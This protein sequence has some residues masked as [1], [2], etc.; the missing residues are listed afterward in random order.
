[1]LALPGPCE[2]VRSGKEEE[3]EEE[4][5][6]VV[7]VVEQVGV[8]RSA[9]RGHVS[10]IWDLQ[11]PRVEPRCLDY[12]SSANQVLLLEGLKNGI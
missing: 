5:V 11:G 1:M 4:E 6:V 9:T 12:S 8:R 2:R 10:S 3:E 7:V